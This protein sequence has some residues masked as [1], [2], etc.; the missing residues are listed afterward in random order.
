M[1]RATQRHLEPF[2]DSKFAHDGHDVSLVR[3]HLA[4]QVPHFIFGDFSGQLGK[5]GAQLRKLF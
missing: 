3:I 2:A 1:T 4:I 5:S